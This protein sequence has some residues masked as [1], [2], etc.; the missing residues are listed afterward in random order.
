MAFIPARIDPLSWAIFIDEPYP[1]VPKEELWG[2]PSRHLVMRKVIH[3]NVHFWHSVTTTQGIRL[4]FDCLKSFNALRFAAK[5]GVDLLAIDAE[6][7]FDEY[8]PF[9][10]LEE[11]SLTGFDLSNPITG[12]SVKRGG[13]NLSPFHLFEGL[14]RYWDLTI[15]AG[16]TTHEV[17][18]A[19]I[20]KESP[21]YSEAYQHAY[22][23]IGDIAFIL[24]PLFGY[25]ALCSD[26]PVES[27]ATTLFYFKERG[28]HVPR[29]VSFQD[30][31]LIAWD[32]TAA[33]DGIYPMPYAPMT[34]YKMQHKR[35][36]RWKLHYAGLIQE[37]F[38]LSGHPILEDV[39]QNMMGLARHRWPHKT[40]HEREG[41]FLIEFVLPGNPE[42]RRTLAKLFPAPIVR[43]GDGRSWISPNESNNTRPEYFAQS[44]QDFSSL[45][46][47]AYGLM[48]RSVGRLM[49]HKCP[50]Q[51]CPAYAYG[52]CGH[53]SEYPKSDATCRFRELL[54][55]E[56]G[57]A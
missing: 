45:M 14:A 38:P 12:N 16:L 37:D 46:G 56:F 44:I 13:P 50:H 47:A 48:R 52:L 32:E 55:Q 30:A 11:F 33:W 36:I 18:S 22:N 23:T 27:F 42:F 9:Q 31:W 5:Q 24:F 10:F 26:S 35:Y 4:A 8:R 25:F 41:Q 51:S 43:F 6:W 21:T 2:F 39:V 17:V 34:T 40:D 53:L 57:I 29:N 1:E 49:K 20:Q 15:S 54:T 19:L 3:E 7:C 28:F